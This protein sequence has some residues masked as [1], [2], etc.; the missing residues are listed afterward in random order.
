MACPPHTLSDRSSSPQPCRR[1]G[2]CAQVA[3]S[4]RG[5]RPVPGPETKLTLP[6]CT[7]SSSGCGGGVLTSLP[8]AG[9]EFLFKWEELCLPTGAGEQVA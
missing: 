6:F 1:R 4:C 8:L 3:T 9:L 7:P 5:L 2:R